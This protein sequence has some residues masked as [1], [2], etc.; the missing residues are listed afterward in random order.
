MTPNKQVSPAIRISRGE[1]DASARATHLEA[2]TRKF[3]VTTNER[4]QM[5]TT[6]NFKRIAL[7]AVAALGMGVLSSAPSQAAWSGTAGS[8]LTLTVANGTAGLTGAASDSTTAGTFGVR[9][10]ALA[11]LDSIGVARNMPLF[12]D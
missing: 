7:V 5:S 6:T 8:S 12:G 2:A 10:L 9:G 3:L 11:A 1:R 4:K